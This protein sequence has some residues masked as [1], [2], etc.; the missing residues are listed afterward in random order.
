MSPQGEPIPAVD[1]LPVRTFWENW[2]PRSGPPIYWVFLVFL[3]FVAAGVVTGV[4][5]SARALLGR[6]NAPHRTA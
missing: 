4:F 5:M 3:A 6:G 2:D 1:D